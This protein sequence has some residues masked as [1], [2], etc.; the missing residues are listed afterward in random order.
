VY[1]LHVCCT[2]NTNLLVSPLLVAS[3]YSEPQPF[4]AGIRGGGKRGGTGPFTAEH[5]LLVC[6]SGFEPIGAPIGVRCFGITG[7]GGGGG[8]GWRVSW[9]AELPCLSAGGR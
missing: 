5:A 7:A 4:H 8:M 2:L 9:L 6:G 1:H 3:P